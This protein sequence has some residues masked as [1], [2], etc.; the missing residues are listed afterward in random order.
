MAGDAG[1]S[2]SLGIV[3]A[4]YTHRR[5]RGWPRGSSSATL[6]S[7]MKEFRVKLDGDRAK[8]GA[9]AAA[10][11]ARLLLL[12]EKAAAQAAAVVLREPKTTTGRYKGPIE[13]AVRFR[14]LG[15]EEGSVVPV[16]ELPET[17]ALDEPTLDLRDRTL[18]E[19]AMESL[20]V[21][22]VEP[23]DPV[24]AKA[25]LDV[26]DGM[27]I[28][29]RYDAITFI[30][31]AED[32]A[33]RKVR[34]DGNGRRRLRRYVESIPTPDPR[35]D[36]LV[37]VLVEA[38]F[39]KRTARLRTPEEPAIEVAFSDEQADAIQSALRQPS[40]VRGEVTYDARTHMAKTVRLREI[41][42]GIEQLV[43][44]PGEFWQELSFA[45]LAERQDAGRP[46]Q[47]H[48]LYDAEASDAERDAVMAAMAELE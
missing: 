39:E 46:A 6:S 36:D 40:T 31:L 18:G 28:G 16:L 48:D 32:G 10:D 2:A 8:L 26:A 29:D 3:T 38:D 47:P 12:V 42:R 15:I 27:L 1:Y 23:H 37:G 30:A 21:A 33:T 24:V 13:Q 35:P 9:V 20:L 4:P 14:L 22:A 45:E 11:V 17:A 44:D 25:L 5:L 43:L 19:A 34:V 41:V 7:S